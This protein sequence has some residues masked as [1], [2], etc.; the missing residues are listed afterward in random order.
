MPPASEEQAAAAVAQIAEELDVLLA[1]V[2]TELR[3]LIG[4]VAELIESCPKP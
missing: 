4:C 1:P 3:R 2:E